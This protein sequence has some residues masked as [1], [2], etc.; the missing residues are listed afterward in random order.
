MY[1]P[2]DSKTGKR[3]V[4]IEAVMVCVNYADFLAQTLPQNVKLLDRIVVVTDTKDKLTKSVCDQYNVECIQTDVFYEDNAV[5][6]KGKGINAGLEVLDKNGWVLHLD[7]DIW[8]S[9]HMKEVLNVRHLDPEAIYGVDRLMCHGWNNW[10]K[11]L[12]KPVAINELYYLVQANAFPIGSRVAHYNQP[13]GWFPI[14]FFQLWN[15]K[16]SGVY[17]YPTN[18]PGADHTDV[19]MSKR[20]PIGKRMPINETYVI[21]LDSERGAMGSNWNGRTTKWF[22]P[23]VQS[24]QSEPDGDDIHLIQESDYFKV[25]KNFIERLLTESTFTI[26]FFNLF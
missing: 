21:H 1:K 24:V 11:F 14:G 22:G 23:E 2:E 18:S 19:V 25:K 5:F 3:A 15:P 16:V 26:K 7:S 6:N 8:L 17:D 4:R 9:P 10:Q 20:F 12:E 13:D